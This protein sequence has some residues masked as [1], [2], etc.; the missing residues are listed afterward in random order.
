MFEVCPAPFTIYYK[1]LSVNMNMLSGHK[2]SSLFCYIRANITIITYMTGFQNVG[3]ITRHDT[4]SSFSNS[5]L[6]SGDGGLYA[7]MLQ[8]RAFQQVTPSKY[9]LW[10]TSFCIEKTDLPARY[11]RCLECLERCQWCNHC[12]C[13][14]H[15]SFYCSSKFPSI[16]S[17]QRHHRFCRRTELRL[18]W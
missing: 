18:F 12:G 4:H 16:G 15:S 1:Q 3:F 11:N 9:K 5:H 13:R 14:Q 17:S 10:F 8:N 2:R 6:K 7:E